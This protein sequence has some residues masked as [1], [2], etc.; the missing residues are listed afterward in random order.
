MGQ[1]DGKVA[2]IT[3]AGRGQGRS[4]AVRFAQEGA[5]VIAV[6][7]CEDLASVPYPLASEADL[8]ETAS[9]IEGLG[10]RV[11]AVKAD[12]RDEQSLAQAL[13]AG[14][15]A[16]GRL[17]IVCANAGVTSLGEPLTMT[18]ETWQ[19]V[20]DINLTGVWQ[21]LKLA[22]P[23]VIEGGRGG[24]MVATGSTASVQVIPNLAHYSASKHGVIAL[25]K[26]FANELGKHNIRVNGVLPTIARSGMV[27]NDYHYRLFQPD[28]EQPTA[29]G[30][31][32]ISKHAHLLPDVGWIEVGEITD[33][34]LFL[35]SD[36]AARITG[37]LL[38]I[39][40]GLLS[41]VGP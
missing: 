11:H 20:I 25:V 8:A 12:V 30:M 7:L 33:A 5:D 26:V 9:Q 27:D 29:D 37:E 36:S 31:I 23:Y 14:V 6:D 10:R 15:E 41:K 13:S 34:V 17:D 35:V 1:L 28:L 3:G 21:T 4:H 24:S 18:R 32:A 16:L 39:D 40:A 22:A 38:T 2:F 19:D